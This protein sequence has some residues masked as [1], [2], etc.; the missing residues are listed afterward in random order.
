MTRYPSPN[1]ELPWESSVEEDRRFK[2]IRRALVVV[3]VLLGLAIPF[4]PVPEPSRDVERELPPQLA[5]VILEREEVPPP[6]DPEPEPEPE[7][8]REEAPDPEPEPE[9]PEPTAQPD[10]DPEPPPSRVQQAR[11][12]A[13]RSGLMQHRDELMAMRETLDTRRVEEAEV[14]QGQAQAEQVE[15]NRLE[16][17][18]QADSGGIDTDQLS[19]D[20]G[21]GE[22][23]AR[24]TTQVE[25][26]SEAALAESAGEASGPRELASRSDEQI[27]QVIDQHMGA[28]FSIYNRALRQDPT[29]QGKL[30]VHM[31]IEPS[32]EISEARV[33]S[34]ELNDEAL[35]QRLLARILL[36]TFP[37]ADVSVTQVNYTFD[38][39]PR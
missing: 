11:E 17:Q 38:F 21:G 5:R 15:R 10:P 4:I 31:V 26:D 14:S 2:R 20:T 30:V 39:L 8:E 18:T 25:G 6:P 32:G 1:T 12:T 3:I 28:I 24:E 29:L 37:D 33:E 7:P 36:I 16:S 35:E 22:L 13:A 23:A 9:A 19:R 27:R 34:S